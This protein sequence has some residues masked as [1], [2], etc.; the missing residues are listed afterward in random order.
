MNQ[1]TFGRP[2]SMGLNNNFANKSVVNNRSSQSFNNFGLGESG[3]GAQKSGKFITKTDALP[4][5]FDVKAMEA[6]RPVN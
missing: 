1:S 4:Q 6:K 5:T 3:Q 2:S